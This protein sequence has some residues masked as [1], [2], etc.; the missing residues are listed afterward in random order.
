[1]SKGVKEKKQPETKKPL[2]KKKGG[3]KILKPSHDNGSDSL[4]D[5]DNPSTSSHAAGPTPDEENALPVR[6]KNKNV[7]EKYQVVRRMVSARFPR[8]A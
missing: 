6:N 8:A 2:A 4:M 1:M 5:I 7:H 3:Q